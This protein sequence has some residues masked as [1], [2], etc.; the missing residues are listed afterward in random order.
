MAPYETVVEYT[1]KKRGTVEHV[2]ARRTDD[3]KYPSGW[4]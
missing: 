3:P 1:V 4:D 2:R